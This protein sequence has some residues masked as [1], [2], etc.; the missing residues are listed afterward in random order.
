MVGGPEAQAERAARASSDVSSG[1]WR[2]P[3]VVSWASP[4]SDG[5]R[6]PEPQRLL[7][8]F[9]YLESVAATCGD[10]WFWIV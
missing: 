7:A 1:R 5:A 3:R 8:P 6:E 2:Q 9:P 10:R 4:T